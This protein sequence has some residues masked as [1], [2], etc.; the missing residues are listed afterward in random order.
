M[1]F[2]RMDLASETKERE[3]SA[4]QTAGGANTSTIESAN[5]VFADSSAALKLARERGLN[6]TAEI[7]TTSPSMLADET[8]QAV[9]LDRELTPKRILSLEDAMIELS[10]ACR[11][12][13]PDNDD[14][15][16]VAGRAALLQLQP[17]LLKAVCLE[18]SDFRENIAVVR[19]TSEDPAL[20]E[21][22]DTPLVDLLSENPNLSV[23]EVPVASLRDVADP[24]PPEPNIRQ[25][26]A[27]ASPGT[28][29]YRLA[30]RFTRKFNLPGPA[31]SV[32]MLRENE[33]NKETALWMMMR[34]Y[35]PVALPMVTSGNERAQTGADLERQVDESMRRHFGEI[36][37]SPALDA[38]ARLFS[39]VLTEQF[40][41]Y[42]HS[43]E[44]WR[45]AFGKYE[46]LR[47]AAVFTNH[48]NNPELVGLHRVLQERR[49]PLVAFQHGVTMEING[50]ISEYDAQF[51][52]A[53]SD[54]EMVFNDEGVSVSRKGRYRRAQSIAT[55]L[56]GDYR[57]GR[58]LRGLT[59]AP[60]IWYLSTALYLANDGLM[61]EG[62]ND[63]DKAA[64]ETALIEGVLRHVKQD[65]LY[66]PYPGRRYLDPDPVLDAA[67]RSENITVYRERIDLRYIVGGARLLVSSR[68]YSTPSW[69]LAS[70]KPYVHIDIPDQAPLTREARS[71][72]KDAVFLFDAGSGGF[73]ADLLE[74][75]NRPLVD[76]E[77]E[78]R[79][80]A[81]ARDELLRK[82]MTTYGDGAGRR[83]ARAVASH[84]NSAA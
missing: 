11:D 79:A 58:R 13:F 2:A 80:K 53:V 18:E 73:E 71:M 60:P 12:L 8:L 30:Q 82:F 77:A 64:F 29:L 40:S 27:F 5:V 69:C 61:A 31:G 49:I 70:E 50:R 41:R 52:S 9:Q 48:L 46:K 28:L 56:P 39:S 24:R 3:V 25:R 36:I 21:E 81:P 43:L 15:A 6:P 47:P 55:G 72:F 14:Y 68:S 76:I 42:E 4:M 26:L 7:R 54:L 32:L 59:D 75:L 16:V 38:V 62:L 44:A 83:A 37:P 17:I 63:R 57:R 23:I 34:G 19:L 78:W 33:L 66:K 1:F 84:I 20:G 65:V 51:D 67:D 45:T 74:F 35:L 10:R 22:L